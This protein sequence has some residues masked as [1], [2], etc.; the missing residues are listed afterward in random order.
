MTKKLKPGD[1]VQ[2]PTS[3]GRT[4]GKVKKR[5]AKATFIKGHKAAA[6]AREPE[7]LVQ[8]LVSGKQAAHKPRTLKKAGKSQ[9]L[10]IL[11]KRNRRK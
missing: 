4:V 11:K 2:W 1:L 5:L 8:S 10:S 3:Q 7:Y 9:V 6:T